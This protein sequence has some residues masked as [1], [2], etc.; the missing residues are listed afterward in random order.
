MILRDYHLHSKFSF[1]SNEE[2]ENICEAAIERGISE[3]CFT[4]HF[5]FGAPDDAI[6]PDIDVWNLE[7]DRLRAVYDGRLSILQGIEAGQPLKESDKAKRLMDQLR[8]RLDFVIGSLHV[9]GDTGRPSK[10][11]FTKQNYQDYFKRYFEEAKE[12]AEFGDF[13][14]MGHITFPFRYPP[15]ELVNEYPIERYEKD[16]REIYDIL[17]SRGKGI[18]INTSGYRTPLED[19]MPGDILVRWYKEQGG[20][21]VTVGSDGHS[22]RS[23]CLNIE[24]GYK[25]IET[26]GFGNLSRCKNRQWMSLQ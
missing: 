14:V 10:Y 3:I 12:L 25:I 23:A 24:K 6:W 9:V 16:I 11:E 20:I 21:I 17:V 19:A 18:E 22:A 15:R 1:D 13:D 26:S 4:E 2:P 7:I 8:N 5:E